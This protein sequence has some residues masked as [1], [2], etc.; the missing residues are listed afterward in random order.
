MLLGGQNKVGSYLRSAGF[1]LI[2]SSTGFIVADKPEVG[3]DRD[4]LL[5]WLPNHLYPGRAFS[6][7]EANLIDK[8]DDQVT[9]YPDARCTIL[10]ESLE[11]IS[12]TFR[13]I[14]SPRGVKIRVPVQFFD[15][16][17]RDELSPEA[18]SS[19]IRSLAGC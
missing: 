14:T 9:R 3:G 7:I 1:N 18:T 19:V 8:I 5:L 11:G 2:N 4:T 17:F 10:V 16:Q 12:R 13:S 15:A 6:Q